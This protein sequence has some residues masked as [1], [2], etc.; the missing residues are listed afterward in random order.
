MRPS[1]NTIDQVRPSETKWDQVDPSETKS[2]DSM[3]V[4]TYEKG[5]SGNG[6]DG[7]RIFSEPPSSTLHTPRDTE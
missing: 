2:T 4:Q 6:D 3:G 7:R 1:E 5:N